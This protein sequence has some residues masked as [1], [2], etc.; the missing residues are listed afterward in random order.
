M[1][2]RI[3]ALCELS[4]ADV[5]DSARGLGNRLLGHRVAL[6]VLVVLVV[7]AASLYGPVKG[8]YA[9]RRSGEDLQRRY[10]ELSEKNDSLQG[11]LKSLTSK[12]GIE[13]EARKRG[14]V[15]EGETSVTVEGLDGQGK[16]DPSAP[17]EYQDTRAWPTKALDFVFGYDPEAVWDE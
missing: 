6:V 10:D 14:Y 9:A 7:V 8:Y 2:R 1:A 16:A 5:A 11:D 4:P 3:S 15:Q 17:V 13:D 12:E